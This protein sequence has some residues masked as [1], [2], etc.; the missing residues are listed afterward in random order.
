[1]AA[2]I[3]AHGIGR[4]DHDLPGERAVLP[5]DELLHRLKSERQNDD[6]GL[7]DG[8]LD[9]CRGGALAELL[10]QRFRVRFLPGCEHHPLPAIDEFPRN[11]LADIP[12]SDHCSRHQMPSFRSRFTQSSR[13]ARGSSSTRG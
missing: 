3:G 4:V 13:L 8:I 5:L 10:S 1:M 9:R 12:E 11:D 2:F 7:R 6:V